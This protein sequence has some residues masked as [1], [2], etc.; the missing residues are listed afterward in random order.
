M[1]LILYYHPLSSYSWKPLIPLYENGTPFD[2]RIIDQDHPENCGEWIASWPLQRF[3]VLRDEERGVTIVEASV[4]VEYLGIHYPGPFAPVPAD[5]DTALE[6]RTL[7]RLFDN[8]V[9]SSMQAYIYNKIRPE[10][11]QDD[12]GLEQAKALLARTYDLLEGRLA[13]RTWAAGEAFSLADCAAGPSLFY[14]DKVQ[15]FRGSHPVLGAYLDRLEARPS[16]ARV[17]AEKEPYWQMF[18]FA[19]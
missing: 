2:G 8:Y 1:S 19:E 11:M 5:P 13:G 15:P 10:G 9:M 18:P 16:F 6:V 4:I 3:P 7:D 17:L 12:Y 14:A